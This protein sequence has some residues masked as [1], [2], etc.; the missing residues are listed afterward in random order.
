MEEGRPIAY[1]SEKL[2][3]VALKY[4]TY[5]KELHALVQALETWEP[6]LWLKEF[7]IHI[8]HESLKYLKG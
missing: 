1:F 5:D 2:I 4:L 7:L 8:N 3:R 6:Y